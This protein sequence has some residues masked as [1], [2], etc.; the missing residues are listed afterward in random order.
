VRE[1]VATTSTT[2]DLQARIAELEGKLA[3]AEDRAARAE[4]SVATW[5]GE[6]EKAH[7][8]EER[9]CKSLDDVTD[10]LDEAGVGAAD[11]RADGIRRLARWVTE[12]NDRATSAAAA[13]ETEAER[14]AEFRRALLRVLGEPTQDQLPD[15]DVEHSD[16]EVVAL[17]RGYVEVVGDVV[18]VL[19]L[20]ADVDPGEIVEEV[21]KLAERAEEDR[22][23]LDA[24]DV[25]RRYH[26]LVE[27]RSLPAPEEVDGFSIHHGDGE[28]V[29]LP[30]TSPLRQVLVDA[31]ARR[32]MEL[33]VEA[34]G[35]GEVARG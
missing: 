35:G 18:D 24:A 15:G 16:S 4:A 9:F 14:R 17:V 34:F 30:A 27:L 32:R 12:A 26:A 8:R 6:V 1:E 22:P 33:E 19:V 21:R 29:H 10:A 31:L 23:R 5:Q 11:S 2:A 20:P 25:E 13:H 7:A 3:A 28:E